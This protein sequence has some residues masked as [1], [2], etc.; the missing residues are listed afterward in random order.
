MKKSAWRAAIALSLIGVAGAAEAS[1]VRITE[2]MYQGGHA[3]VSGANEWG[4]FV[5][6][7]N[8][9]TTA[10]DMTS[11]SFDDD[12]RTA[13]SVNFGSIFGVVAPGQSVILTDLTAAR[14]RSI[15]S[16]DSSV[17]VYGNNGA[18]LGRADELNLYNSSGTLEDRLTFG[19]QSG[20]GP[21]TQRVSA[22]PNSLAALG[23]NTANTWILSS[24]G[25]AE[26]S[27]RSSFA[28][29]E[30][31]ELGNPGTSRFAPVPLPAAAWL[32]LSGLGAVGA[33]SRRRAAKAAA[34]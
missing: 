25:D 3:G 30:L 4:E 1:S 9:G 11:W 34:A 29:A 2:Y 26:G 20:L 12:S 10:V 33:F 13:G 19:D 23:A 27:R 8:I 31:A 18:N 5:E 24:I 22:N 32:M 15:W 17:K 14:F 21:R 7:T 16:L 6:F 28:A